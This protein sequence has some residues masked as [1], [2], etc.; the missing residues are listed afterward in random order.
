MTQPLLTI[1]ADAKIIAADPK[2]SL[3]DMIAA[4][5]TEAAAIEGRQADIVK[6]A[7]R[8]EP[9]RGQMRRAAIFDATARLLRLI[10][11]NQAA[12]ARVLKQSG[13]AQ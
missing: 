9:D 2:P 13:G 6:G 5:E 8:S 11:Q 7:L 12:V 10:K 1:M 4:A 3:D